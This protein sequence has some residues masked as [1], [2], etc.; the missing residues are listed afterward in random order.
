MA[1]NEGGFTL[2]ELLLVLSIVIVMSAIL[3]PVGDKWFKKNEEENT[4]Q[5][6]VLAVHSMQ[7][8]AMAHGV[9]TSLK[10]HSDGDRMVYVGSASGKGEL[11]R[12]FLPEG[13][14][15]GSS[16]NLKAVEF[17]ADGNIVNSGKLIL[18]GKSGL[19]NIVFQFQRGRMII[20]ESA[21]VFMAGNNPHPLRPNHYFWYAT[22]FRNKNDKSVAYQEVI[23]ARC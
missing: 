22:S 14:R 12:K 17:R 11:F 4:V 21:R 18:V 15:V 23:D 16:S 1:R 20:S 9:L 5:S 10:F 8:Y 19:I 6:I 2:L 3:I 13:M 7:S